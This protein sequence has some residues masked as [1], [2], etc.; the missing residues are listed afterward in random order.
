MRDACTEKISYEKMT[1]CKSKRGNLQV[2]QTCYHLN[3]GFLASRTVKKEIAIK[4]P[5]LWYFVMAALTN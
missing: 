4:C 1:I 5:S 2:N 3:L